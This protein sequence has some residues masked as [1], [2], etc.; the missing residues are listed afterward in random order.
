MLDE[1]GDQQYQ[2][3][4]ECTDELAKQ[5]KTTPANIAAAYVLQTPGVSAIIL[6]PRNSQHIA[7][8]DELAQLKL[9]EKDYQQLHKLNIGRNPGIH[10]DIYSYERNQQGPHGRIMKYNLNGMKKTT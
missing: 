9:N 2:D 10:K 4:L 1:I 6:G 8:L 7:E 5:Y 3:V